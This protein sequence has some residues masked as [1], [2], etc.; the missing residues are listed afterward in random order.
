MA[1]L[2]FQH[3]FEHVVVEVVGVSLKPHLKAF[4]KQMIDDCINHLDPAQ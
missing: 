4:Y 1:E 2:L 3:L